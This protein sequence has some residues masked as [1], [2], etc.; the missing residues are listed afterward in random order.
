MWYTFGINHITHPEDWPIMPADMA[1]FCLKPVGFFNRNS[2]VD[3]APPSSAQCHR[4][5]RS[6]L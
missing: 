5:S 1:F 6:D 3:V 4:D 2:A